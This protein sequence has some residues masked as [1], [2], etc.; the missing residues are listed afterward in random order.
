MAEKTET[1]VKEVDYLAKIG[2]NFNPTNARELFGDNA[3]QALDAVAAAGGYGEHT[4]KEYGN[5]LFGGFAIP[6]DLVDKA[7]DGEYAK[8]RARINAALNGVK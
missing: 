6:Y 5:P 1:N 3:V 8:I 7:R 2:R 4:E